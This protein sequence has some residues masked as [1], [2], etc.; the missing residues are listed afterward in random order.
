VILDTLLNNGLIIIIGYFHHL[1]VILR[2][3]RYVVFLV[4]LGDLVKKEA[5][6]VMTVTACLI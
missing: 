1:P 6:I 5:T 3:K 4:T 2:Y